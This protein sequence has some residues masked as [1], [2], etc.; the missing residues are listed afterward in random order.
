M[1]VFAQVAAHVAQQFCLSSE[2][3]RVE[4]GPRVAPN[5]NNGKTG[6]VNYSILSVQPA[7]KQRRLLFR[8]G[9]PYLSTVYDADFSTRP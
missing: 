4:K 5:L 6:C 1:E 7:K 9:I 3:R 8:G 2:D